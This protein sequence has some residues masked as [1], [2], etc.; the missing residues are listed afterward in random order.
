MVQ[1]PINPP[2]INSI[3]NWVS[4][5]HYR[6]SLILPQEP[7]KCINIGYYFDSQLSQ[8]YTRSISQ[9]PYSFFQTPTLCT[10]HINMT[11]CICIYHNIS[12]KNSPNFLSSFIKASP[13]TPTKNSPFLNEICHSFLQ[14][15]LLFCILKNKQT[16]LFLPFLSLCFSLFSQKGPCLELSSMGTNETFLAFFFPEP[17]HLKYNDF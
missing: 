8:L 2:G 9:S 15:E 10:I 4:L 1:L 3:E 17:K 14:E 16:S 7:L 11:C 5:G 12:G 13:L 6:V